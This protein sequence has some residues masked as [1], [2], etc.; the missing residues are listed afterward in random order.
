MNRWRSLFADAMQFFFVPFVAALLPWRWATRWLHWWSARRGGP[1]DEAA[2]AAET[3]APKYLD[4]GSAEAFARALRLTWLL[5]TCDAYL[6]LTRWRRSWWPRYV[7]QV[8]AWPTCGAFIAT[9]FHHGTGLWVFRSLARAGRD[10]VLVAARWERADYRG[11]PL[12]YWY[13]RLRAWDVERI[14]GQPIAFRPGVRDR[15]AAALASGTPVVGVIDMPPR[16]A[17]RGQRRVR[18]LDHDIC[19]PDGLLVLARAAGVP[20]VPDWVEFDLQ[21]CT[22]RF[23]IGEPLDPNDASGTLQVLAD[24]LDRQIRRTPGAWFFWP[25]WPAWVSAAAQDTP[26]REGRA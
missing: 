13:G 2:R 18:L 19:F 24:I 26:D 1:F 12:R 5:D 15:L 3:I 8:G 14:S 10:S 7:Q 9:G 11:L 20:L 21:N 22:R 17:P 23:C 6:S 25:E 4:V 16:L